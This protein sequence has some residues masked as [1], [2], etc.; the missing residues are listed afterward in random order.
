[1]PGASFILTLDENLFV[2]F[3]ELPIQPYLLLIKVLVNLVRRT[4]LLLGHCK[5]RWRKRGM[6]VGCGIRMCCVAF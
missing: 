3:V 1:M 4:L 6:E 5:R 2:E